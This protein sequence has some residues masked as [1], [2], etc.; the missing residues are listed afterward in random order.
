MNNSIPSNP[1]STDYRF[2][3]YTQLATGISLAILSPVTIVSNVLLL[4]TVYKDPLKCFRTPATCLIVALALVDL[5]TGLVVEP[6]FVIYRVASYVKWSPY[7]GQSYYNLLLIGSWISTVCLNSSFLLV[8]ALIW[9]QFI[10]ITYPQRYR[11]FVTTRRVLAFVAFSWL[12]L[13]GFTL[14]QFAG[15]SRET[16]L[17]VN[18]H[19]HSTLIT[20]LLIVG[21]AILLKSLRRL[22]EA[23]RRLED[24]TSVRQLTIV[25]LLLSAILIVSALP[26]VIT[27]HIWFYAKQETLQEMLDLSAVLTIEDEMLFIKVACDAFIYAWRLP[28]YRKSLKLVLTCTGNQGRHHG[29]TE[30]TEMVTMV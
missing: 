18:L 2:Y 5:T 17:Q 28:H 13:T 11:F 21:S 19:F 29:R 30:A 3:L 14:L 16:L 27:L 22:L 24:E 26:H 15:V 1:S 4:L 7:V 6:F 8:L 9:S 25:T 10:A 12:Y 23:S 20:I